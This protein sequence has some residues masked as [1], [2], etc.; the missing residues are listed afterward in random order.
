MGALWTVEMIHLTVV[1]GM[2][3]GEQIEGLLAPLQKR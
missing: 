1:S 3:T 2:A